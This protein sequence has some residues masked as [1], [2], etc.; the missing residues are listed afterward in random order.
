MIARLPYWVLTNATPSVYESESKTAVEMVAKVY[1]KMQEL[2]DEYNKFTE[3]I[4][5]TI[6]TFINDTNINQEEF[7]CRITKVIH[8]YL[9]YLDTRLDKQD[10]II[11]ESV[12]Y[13]KNNLSGTIAEL[14]TQMKESGE[15]D[16]AIINSFNN[17]EI[18]LSAIE[19]SLTHNYE[20]ES[21]TLS[22]NFY[23]SNLDATTLYVN[24]VSSYSIDEPNEKV[25]IEEEE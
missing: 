6:E 14:V 9:D 8:D 15:I 7:E 19:S 18:R 12:V 22:L 2:V 3:T 23:E 20:S 11:N 5:S 16:E 21:E 4:N 17:L 25:N 13:M 10:T 24:N 1:A